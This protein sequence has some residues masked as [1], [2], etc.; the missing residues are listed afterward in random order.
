MNKMKNERNEWL[1]DRDTLQHKV[2]N[3]ERIIKDNKESDTGL[4]EEQLEEAKDELE[5]AQRLANDL[6]ERNTELDD[7]N[8]TLQEK[9]QLE[10][11]TFHRFMQQKHTEPFQSPPTA[12][13]SGHATPQELRNLRAQLSREYENQLKL[14]EKAFSK[15]KNDAIKILDAEYNDIK[16]GLD[17]KIANLENSNKALKRQLADKQAEVQ[18]L[19]DENGRMD[20]LKEE[21]AALQEAL[22]QKA[23]EIIKLKT[24]LSKYK[25][26]WQHFF[27]LD[28]PLRDEIERV[29]NKLDKFEHHHGIQ[30]PIPKKKRRVIIESLSQVDFKSPLVLDAIPSPEDEYQRFELYNVMEK[31]RVVEM[32]GFKLRNEKGVEIDVPDSCQ[33]NPGQ[34]IGVCLRKRKKRSDILYDQRAHDEPF[35]QFQDGEVIWLCD[36]FDDKV[37]L[38]PITEQIYDSLN[39][40]VKRGEA[41]IYVKRLFDEEE[42]YRGFEF[43]NATKKKIKFKGMYFRNKRETLKLTVPMKALRSNG[44]IKLVITDNPQHRLIGKNDLIVSPDK[45]QHGDDALFLC[46]SYG[47]EIE[48]YNMDSGRAGSGSRGRMAECFIM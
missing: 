48:L 11:D 21:M 22:N 3:L 18:R 16:Q 10:K 6:K 12:A 9:L 36:S 4:L 17:E 40:F 35:C 27:G 32:K 20:E 23:S 29:N 31:Q 33:V 7:E 42:G 30:S 2:E 43:G 28:A 19:R 37:Q 13:K 46:D 39:V 25:I 34:C 44:I 5:K 24:E 15:A 8:G 14:R 38:F 1:T 47:N 26:L 41:P 45:I